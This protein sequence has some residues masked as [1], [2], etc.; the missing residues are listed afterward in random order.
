MVHCAEGDVVTFKDTSSD[1]FVAGEAYSIVDGEERMGMAECLKV[2]VGM[3]T[4]RLP[5]IVGLNPS[6]VGIP[7]TDILEQHLQR[8]HAV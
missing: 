7:I 3:V 5:R 8:K 2:E 6:V 4:L 1:Q